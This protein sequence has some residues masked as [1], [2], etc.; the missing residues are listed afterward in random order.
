MMT[1][2]ERRGGMGVDWSGYD[3]LATELAVD[4]RIHLGVTENGVYLF[5]HPPISIYGR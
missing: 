5:A 2:K 4:C 1:W 3:W